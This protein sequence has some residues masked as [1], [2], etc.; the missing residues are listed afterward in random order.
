MEPIGILR[1]FSILENVLKRREVFAAMVK[2]R[3]KHDT[4]TQAMTF[5]CQLFE[6]GIITEMG[7][8]FFIVNRVV[9]VVGIGLE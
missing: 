5:F 6:Q 7:V 9:F 3:V 1:V 8:D 4:Y 2:H